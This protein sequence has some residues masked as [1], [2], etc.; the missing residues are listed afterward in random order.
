MLLVR[1]TRT[2]FVKRFSYGPD[3]AVQS[4]DW[5]RFSIADKIE[6]RSQTILQGPV[7][8]LGERIVR[9][10]EVAGSIPARSTNLLNCFPICADPR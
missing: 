5:C 6:I 3:T 10:D 8:Q 2:V 9:N 1:R 7:A 4:Q